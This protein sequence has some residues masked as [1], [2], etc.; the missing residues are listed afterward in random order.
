MEILR[1]SQKSGSFRRQVNSC[2]A[3][4]LFI[5]RKYG[6]IQSIEDMDRVFTILKMSFVP[7]QI[8]VNSYYYKTCLKNLNLN[9]LSEVL[10]RNPRRN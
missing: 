4:K 10:R 9:F 7:Q 8:S 1:G 2:H 6:K 5:N 3:I